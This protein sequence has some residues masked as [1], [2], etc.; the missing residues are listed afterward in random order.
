MRHPEAHVLGAFGVCYPYPAGFTT[1]TPSTLH[2]FLH[3]DNL[4]V[5]LSMTLISG[6]LAQRYRDDQP[7]Y[8]LGRRLR[9]PASLV[10]ARTD[11]PSFARSRL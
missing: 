3:V 10:A 1:L 7:L 4:P 6:L 11:A 8:Y 9:G 5:L 2:C